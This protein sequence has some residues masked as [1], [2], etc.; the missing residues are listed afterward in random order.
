MS[1]QAQRRTQHSAPNP[2]M[3]PSRAKVS[4]SAGLLASRVV[5]FIAF[6]R[7][8]AVA[9]M[10]ASR[11][12]LRAQPRSSTAFPFDPRTEEPIVIVYAIVGVGRKRQRQIPSSADVSL[13]AQAQRQECRLRPKG[14]GN[15]KTAGLA[16]GG[17][18]GFGVRG[19]FLWS[20]DG[21]A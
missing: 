2:P 8:C 20:R 11:L 21:A 4:R 17:R 19:R 16:G 6:P 14:I 12:Q 18:R 7:S 3:A 5:A 15:D 10:S 9:V 13:T 1:A